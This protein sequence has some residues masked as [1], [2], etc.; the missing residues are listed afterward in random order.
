MRRAKLLVS[1]SVQGVGFRYFTCGEARALGLTGYVRN[2]D[3]GRV[4]AVVEGP[5]EDVDELIAVLRQGPSGA[6]VEDV[7]VEEQPHRGEF[8]SFGVRF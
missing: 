4:E 5:A 2:L 6:W 7:R 1:G 8:G 3:D